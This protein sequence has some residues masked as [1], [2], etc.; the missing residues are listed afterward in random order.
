MRCLLSRSSF[1]TVKSE[2][3]RSSQLWPRAVLFLMNLELVQRLFHRSPAIQR[4]WCF[5]RK[6][7]SRS[8]SHTHTDHP[9]FLQTASE[10]I[11]ALKPLEDFQSLQNFS[12]FINFKAYS[13]LILGIAVV[14]YGSL[15]AV[16]PCGKLLCTRT[17]ERHIAS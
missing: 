10:N 2:R 15:P 16:S 9:V 12:C 7:A 6:E 13:N 17:R 11:L 8:G 14:I 3:H 1:R 4:H 5:C